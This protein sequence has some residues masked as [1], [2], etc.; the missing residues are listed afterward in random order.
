[1]AYNLSWVGIGSRLEIDYNKPTPNKF[2][3]NTVLRE[4]IV[5]RTK[6]A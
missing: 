6:Y 2:T 4:N 5:I 3:A 1:M